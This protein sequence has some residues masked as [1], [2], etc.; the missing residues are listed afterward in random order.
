MFFL[1]VSVYFLLSCGAAWLIFFPNG[2]EFVS[3]IFMR[4]S[5]RA[6][7]NYL[8][9]NQTANQ[10]LGSSKTVLQ[11]RY[12]QSVHFI[13]SNYLLVMAM[14]AVLLL[15]PV[16][17]WMFS[18]Y[19]GLEGFETESRVVNTQIADLL[20][21]EQLVPPAPLP[22]DIFST[23]EVLQ[24]R[25]MLSGA[26]RNWDLLNL[27]FR[28]R[29]LWVFK[30]MRERHGYEMAIIEGYR[31]PERQNQLAEL[32]AHV[33]NAKAFQSYHQFGYAADCAFYRNGK[34]VI[35][36]KD[37]WAMR[38]YELYGEL[39]EAAGLTWG[40]RWKLMDYG[41]S[42]LRKPGVLGK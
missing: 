33:T 23:L 14:S 34:L 4:F 29:L 16:L 28:Q 38:G 27:E 41:H 37:A 12:R 31:S 22:P 20:K 8:H 2:R 40:G 42:E 18:E 17:A 21:G 11:D 10:F 39:A 35:S 19:R 36:E 6:E 26:S 3:G 15:P 25:P 1:V 13:K 5:A 30:E 7:K 24:E 9:A 32:G